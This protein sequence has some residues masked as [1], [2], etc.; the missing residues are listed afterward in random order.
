MLAIL[1]QTYFIGSSG[2]TPFHA[3]YAVFLLAA[4]VPLWRPHSFAPVPW[5]EKV[6]QSYELCCGDGTGVGDGITPLQS[7][8]DMA[9]AK[10][11]VELEVR[12]AV[13]HRFGSNR[14]R[15]WLLHSSNQLL[16]WAYCNCRLLVIFQGCVLRVTLTL[17]FENSRAVRKPPRRWWNFYNSPWWE[18]PPYILETSY[19][20][21]GGDKRVYFPVFVPFNIWDFR[22][23]VSFALL[24]FLSRDTRAWYFPARRSRSGT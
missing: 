21:P 10:R 22:S 18:L 17:A 20:S 2:G 1:S 23:R 4:I 12:R 7:A 16:R 15:P 8:F 14:P 3:K 19:F 11:Y 24:A 13:H 6:Y 9:G 5:R